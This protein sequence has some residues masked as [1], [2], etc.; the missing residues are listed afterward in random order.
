[1]ETNKYTSEGTESSRVIK[2]DMSKVIEDM[3][4]KNL[5]EDQLPEVI[6][7]LEIIVSK[8]FT[9]EYTTEYNEKNQE[10]IIYV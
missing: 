1:M 6:E 9:F 3:K 8:V 5:C 10:F 7:C 4:N 2:T